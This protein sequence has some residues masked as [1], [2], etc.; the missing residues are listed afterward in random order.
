MTG[1][2]SSCHL[3]LVLSVGSRGPGPPAPLPSSQHTNLPSP[4]VLQDGSQVAGLVPRG[5]AGINDVG[6]GSRAEEE[7]REAAGLQKAKAP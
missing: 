5:S 7:G 4:L 3:L 6:A 2:S 1:C